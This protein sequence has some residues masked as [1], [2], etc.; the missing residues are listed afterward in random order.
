MSVFL[1]PLALVW[2]DFWEGSRWS[3]E[4]LAFFLRIHIPST[5]PTTTTHITGHNILKIFSSGVWLKG[6]GRFQRT[7]CGSRW[8][9]FCGCKGH[10]PLW[11]CSDP[12]LSYIEDPPLIHLQL[13]SSLPPVSALTPSTCHSCQKKELFPRFFLIADNILFTRGNTDLDRHPSWGSL[14]NAAKQL[15]FF[16][17]SGEYFLTIGIYRS[18]WRGS[19]VSGWRF[20]LCPRS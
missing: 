11:P 10:R 2:P 1:S 5:F 15:V 14:T 18:Q 17:D 7:T 8:R 9:S 13:V 20:F 16:C 6:T 3:H 12:G 4:F 19:R